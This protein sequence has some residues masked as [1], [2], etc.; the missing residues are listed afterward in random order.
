MVCA[1]LTAVP[2]QKQAYYSENPYL[3]R[4]LY[5]LTAPV[6]LA[7]HALD[8]C[9][10]IIVSIG[11]FLSAGMQTNCLNF[12]NNSLNMS[13]TGILTQPY[14]CFIK[15][16]SLNNEVDIGKISLISKPL[17]SEGLAL[18]GKLREND[19][20]FI[21]HVGTRAV[22]LA[23]IVVSIFTRTTEA[24]ICVIAVPLSILFL[25]QISV[26][27]NIAVSSLA[28]PEIIYEFFLNMLL[29]INPWPA[30]PKV[31]NT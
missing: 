4:G 15:F 23:L 6:A 8:M 16:I 5:L 20:L 17:T 19:N 1:L 12:A 27:N 31:S 21:R 11:V 7:S 30:W 13:C 2:L 14:K 22:A 18:I 29:V 3:S 10:G 24:V 26:L 9:I 25:G 28:F